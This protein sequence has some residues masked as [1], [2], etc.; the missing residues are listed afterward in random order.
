MAYKNQKK[1]KRHNAEL[2]T[3]RRSAKRQRKQNR[4]KPPAPLSLEQMEQMISRTR[5]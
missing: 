1:N 5:F 3:K 2:A 4:K